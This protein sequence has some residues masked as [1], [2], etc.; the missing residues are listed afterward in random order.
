MVCFLCPKEDEGF[1]SEKEVKKMDTD[2]EYIEDDEEFE[3]DDNFEEVE[4]DFDDGFESIYDDPL[5]GILFE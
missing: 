1:L 4:D 5:L 2:S 3:D